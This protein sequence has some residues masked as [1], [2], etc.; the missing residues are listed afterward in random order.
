MVKAN[1]DRI[2]ELLSEK[3]SLSTSDLSRLLSISGEDVLKS[4]EYLEQDGAVKIERKFPRTVVTLLK[5][6]IPPPPLASLPLPLPSAAKLPIPPAPQSFTSPNISTPPSPILPIPPAPNQQQSNIPAPL[7]QPPLPLGSD[8]LKRPEVNTLNNAPTT[9]TPF[10]APKLNLSFDRETFKV[11]DVSIKTTTSSTRLLIDE[12]PLE[13]Q[14]H[15]TLDAP[16]P[17]GEPITKPV[18]SYTKEFN[19]NVRTS[20]P[21]YIKTDMERVDFMLEEV[22]DKIMKREFNDLNVYYRNIYNLFKRSD[23]LTPNERYLLSEKI[24]D[25]FDKIKNVYAYE[26]AI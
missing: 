6:S 21:S 5:S 24:N 12:N 23:N 8:I 19:S 18:F 26:G 13:Q 3:K 20:Y 7:N 1:V 4:A 9:S 14:A 2:L 10:E 22:E 15:F 16:T 11:P 25:I 17:T